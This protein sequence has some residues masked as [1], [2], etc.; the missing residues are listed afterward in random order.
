MTIETVKAAL[1]YLIS[2]GKVS[3]NL[4]YYPVE[5]ATIITFLENEGVIGLDKPENIKNHTNK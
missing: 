2:E 1:E 5:I 3:N 4:W